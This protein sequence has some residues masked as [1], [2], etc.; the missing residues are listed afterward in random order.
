MLRIAAAV[1]KYLGLDSCHG[2]TEVSRFHIALEAWIEDYP[3]LWRQ[4]QADYSKTAPKRVGSMGYDGR[5][6]VPQL[7]VR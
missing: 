1:G 6:S 4:I 2:C 7:G 3:Q 5:T